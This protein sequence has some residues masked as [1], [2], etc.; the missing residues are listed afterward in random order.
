MIALSTNVYYF[1][2]AA[3][4]SL[5]AFVTLILVP[6]LTSFGRWPERMAAG[7]LSLFLLGGLVVIGVLAGLAWVLISHGITGIFPWSDS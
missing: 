6:A 1:G 2:A 5:A 7:F 4:I 3:L